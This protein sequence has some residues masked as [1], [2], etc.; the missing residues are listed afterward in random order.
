VDGLDDNPHGAECLQCLQA[1]ASTGRSKTRLLILSQR[2]EVLR[3]AL[4]NNSA[5]ISLSIT[6]YS[7]PDILQ[8][9]E[10]KTGQ[11]LDR[12]P[13][14]EPKRNA[15]IRKLQSEVG[16]VF[17]LVN[18]AMHGL[19]N[20]VA[21]VGDVDEYLDNLPDSLKGV[22]DKI[23]ARLNHNSEDTKT[24]MRT[25]LQFLA[26]SAVP[27][28]VLNLHHALKVSRSMKDGPKERVWRSKWSRDTQADASR[29]LTSLLDSLIEIDSNHFVTLV[30]PSLRR[31]LLATSSGS[32][33]TSNSS[34]GSWYQFPA[35]EAHLLVSEICVAVCG[36][37]TLSQ[38]NAFAGTLPP[39]LAYAWNYWAYHLRA[40][41]FALGSD[42]SRL[43]LDRML[44]HV[45]RDTLSF[46]FALGDFISKPLEPVRGSYTLLEYRQSLQQAQGSL[47]LAIDALCQARQSIPVAAKLREA[48]ARVPVDLS[49]LPLERKY[50][51]SM[52]WVKSAISGLRNWLLKDQ[53]QVARVKLD[54]LME[55]TA[56]DTVFDNST[57]PD[58]VATLLN[59]SRSLRLVALSFSVNPLHAALVQKAGSSGFSPIN[60]LVYVAQLLEEAA[61]FP[62]WNH[63]PEML[64]PAEAFLCSASDPQAGPAKSVIRS[65]NWQRL[66]KRLAA[67]R[68]GILFEQID[69]PPSE[70]LGR[71]IRQLSEVTAHRWVA[72]RY[73]LDVFRSAGDQEGEWFQVLVANPLINLHLKNKLFMLGSSKDPWPIFLSPGATLDL[74]AP[75][76]ILDAPVKEIARAV[77]AMLKF[78]YI[79][80]VTMLLELF[81]E[82]PRSS[83]VAH[84]VQLTTSKR[85]L[86]ECA[87]Y[88]KQLCKTNLWRLSHAPMVL[89][90][91]WLRGKICPWLGAHAMAHPWADLLLSYRHPVAYLN[92]QSVHDVKFWFKYALTIRL[93]NAIGRIFVVY[94]QVASDSSLGN[95]P[96]LFLSD[97][98][99]TLHYL[100]AAERNLFGLGFAFA[101]LMASAKVIL[102]DPENLSA[103][104]YFTFWYV[105]VNGFGIF[106]L[107]AGATLQQNR[108]SF[109]QGLPVIV[110]EVVVMIALVMYQ[111]TSL[112]ILVW[113]LSWVLW[114]ITG[115]TM[116]MWNL[117][118]YIY[119]PFLKFCGVVAFIIMVVLAVAW[120]NKTIR[121]PHDLE[122]SRKAVSRALEKVASMRDQGERMYI[123]EFP[124][125]GGSVPAEDIE[126]EEDQDSS[127]YDLW[128][129]PEDLGEEDTTLG[130]AESNL[131]LQAVRG[132][133]GQDP[134]Q[135][136]KMALEKFGEIAA[137]E[138]S[139]AFEQ[140]LQTFQ[141]MRLDS[142]RLGSF[143]GSYRGVNFWSESYTSTSGHDPF[144]AGNASGSL[145]NSYSWVTN[146]GRFGGLNRHF[147][148]PDR[149][150]LFRNDYT[151]YDSYQ[152]KRGNGWHFGGQRP[153]DPFSML[154]YSYTSTDPL[155]R[156]EFFFFGTVVVL[157]LAVWA[158]IIWAWWTGQPAL[159]SPEPEC[160]HIGIPLG[161]VYIG[162]G[163]DGFFWEILPSAVGYFF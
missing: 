149:N 41:E 11:L 153:G 108:A 8:Y 118:L 90:L 93:Y 30:H 100:T 122:G 81:A 44:R 7:Q 155:G 159:A 48:R 116:A 95:M 38:A 146:T 134:Q 64:D 15:I 77:P 28:T 42:T 114:P 51:R 21:Q 66:D 147:R 151:D 45:H 9:I 79:K 13:T 22:Y 6:D 91:F 144:G 68:L 61:S 125:G 27:I 54:D 101:V 40:S 139:K 152:D 32:W 82:V 33:A 105:V 76:A 74:R 14:F 121:D 78:A 10:H 23:F 67:A 31:T 17:E 71:Q 137:S 34:L 83:V 50:R 119:A 80:Y 133:V 123:G 4:E 120:L 84:F 62:Y 156:R 5:T 25:A 163:C 103:V 111:T 130:F 39:L 3:N 94:S 19:E 141:N 92:L 154:S 47:P 96:G 124:L 110:F 63:L 73:A 29:D 126:G 53:T 98:L 132:N 87:Q 140:V 35:T 60:L 65:V 49:D 129:W 136:I 157:V 57:Y 104:G 102:Y 161:P 112:R 12:R 43:A 85:E 128:A 52:K 109:L 113:I 127:G 59:T 24:R 16:G 46:L 162:Y 55:Q 160:W 106:N 148:D 69:T 97:T 56:I 115:P 158:Y 99:A 70:E 117:G 75:T 145:D 107:F 2:Q 26:V 150:S 138:F 18:T 88:A 143:D 131:P 36:D 135:D 1:V 89:L 86:L 37:T 20:H 58:P 142:S 72:M